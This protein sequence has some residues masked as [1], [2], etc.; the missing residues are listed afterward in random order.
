MNESAG[1]DDRFMDEALQEARRGRYSVSPNPAVGCVIVRDGQIIGRGFHARP[2][3]PHAEIAALESINREAAGATAFVTLEP[4]NHHGRTG[5]CAEALIEAG[6]KRVVYANDDI[7]P[8]VAGGGRACLEAAGLQVLSGVRSA[9]AWALNAGF[10]KR[11]RTEMPFV[12]V[13]LAMSLDGAVALASGESQWIT[14]SC[15]RSDVQRLRAEACVIVTGAG[16]V[17]ADDPS[18]S[19]RDPALEMRGRVP[20][21]AILDSRL[22]VPKK[23]RLF[24]LP[25][26]KLLFCASDAGARAAGLRSQGATVEVVDA[27]ARGLNLTAVLHRLAALECND[28]LV[29]AG[30]TLAGAFLEA[31]LVDELVLYIA[32]R[33][34]GLEGRRAF[35]LP[36]PERLKDAFALDLV[37]TRRLDEDIALTLRPRAAE[38]EN[39][40]CLPG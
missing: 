22:R 11:A 23:S 12:R 37:D 36:S 10:F 4:C 16:T 24:T 31:Q 1:T 6:I 17:V 26:R 2:G 29:E 7:N 20:A 8:A 5:P 28:V 9:E 25:G 3:G 35:R 40:T 38:W 13:K 15:A 33:L 34:L 39:K 27:D 14:G 19:V 18:L 32:P 30:P 21:L